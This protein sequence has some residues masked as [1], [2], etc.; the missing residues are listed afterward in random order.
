MLLP[1]YVN[2]HP[3]F[4]HLSYPLSKNSVNSYSLRE[5]IDY[6]FMQKTGNGNTTAKLMAAILFSKKVE[7]L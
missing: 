6:I 4:F 3:S 7:P 5:D 1:L 2:A